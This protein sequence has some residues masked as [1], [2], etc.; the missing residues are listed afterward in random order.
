MRALHVAA[1]ALVALAGGLL[2]WADEVEASTHCRAS[3]N[4]CQGYAWVGTQTGGTG[5]ER[6]FAF[7]TTNTAPTCSTS[8]LT[9][10][11]E[12]TWE[13]DAGQCLSAYYFGTTAGLTPP[14]APNKLTI[15]VMFDSSTANIIKTYQFEGAEP[16]QDG[17]Q[18]KFTFC[19][20][21]NGDAGGSAR[22]G[23]YRLWLN[24]IKDNGNGLPGNTNYNI[25]T[26]G[27]ATQG[28][29][30]SGHFD[31]G[32]LRGLQVIS[33]ITRNAYPAG[34]TFAY[35]AASDELVTVTATI[36]QPNGDANVECMNTGV[37]DDATQAVGAL[38][39][40]FDIDAT[41]NVIQNY[42]VDQTFPSA[43]AP[44]RMLVE[45]GKCNATL[46]GLPWTRF[47]ATGHGAGI[48]RDGDYLAHSSSTFSIDPGIRLD[49]DS[50]GGYASADE[51]DRSYAGG[52]CSGTQVELFNRGEAVCTAWG[53]T[54][55]RS[56]YLSRAMTFSRM[57]AT[58]TVCTALGSLTPTAGVYTWTGN[59]ETATTCAAAADLTGSTRHLQVTNTD[60][61]YASGTIYHVSSLY[62]VTAHTQE[63]GAIGS[64]QTQFF[65]R[66]DGAGGD[67]SDTIA[68]YCHVEGVRGDVDIDTSGSAVTRSIIDPTPTTRATGATDTDATGWT[69][70]LSL[71]ATTPLGD[72]W[73]APCS[74]AFNGNTGSD[75]QVFEVGVEGGGG[76]TVYTG[77]DPLTI[78][79][80]NV[81]N[82]SVPITVHSRL[83]DGE[84]RVG[85]ADQIFVSVYEWPAMTPVVTGGAVVEVDS[86]NAPGSY[87]YN[88]TFPG[89]GAYLIAANTTDGA[90]PIGAHNVI[91]L[92]NS[93]VADILASLN[94]HRTNSLEILGMSFN[95]LE[96]DGFLTWLVWLVLVLFFLARSR[97][98]AGFVATLGLA[99]ALFPTVMPG[100]FLGYVLLLAIGVWI[101][102][103]AGEKI[104]Q[105]WLNKTPTKE[106]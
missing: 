22:A 16:V 106:T 100:S 84:A 34:S 88:L 15:R 102:A 60:Q 105:K 96:F 68:V 6:C 65:I 104:Y 43:S 36:S 76:E 59:L 74:V 94:G 19:A 31:K 62:L 7:R 69:A 26:D 3:G 51:T 70:A 25:N 14:A 71:L 49:S 85:V 63:P 93:T 53:V 1:V 39:S 20:T 10:T 80:G 67:D 50:S 46:T 81:A 18:N 9:P 2:L 21:S 8:G 38:G 27:V 75:T 99:E 83:L 90:T 28:S 89:P 44:Y 82:G 57:D 48:V 11:N 32:A 52:T 17:T 64:E 79:G 33:S 42:V 4:W 101:E 45:T 97:V 98:F 35:G 66:D 55:A 41:N 61:S 13:L 12:S 47:A 54:N 37:V 5:S 91:V 58:N 30:P 72:D 95:N 23:T 56:E 73:T 103:V 29:I 78:F 92:A 77:A 87:V 86:V 24:A 40:V